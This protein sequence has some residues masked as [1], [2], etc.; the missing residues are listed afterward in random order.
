MRFDSS[1]KL[2]RA[3]VKSQDDFAATSMW[4]VKNGASKQVETVDGS[5]MFGNFDI[6]VKSTAKPGTELGFEFK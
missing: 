3:S 6:N 4:Q 1:D 2:N 5:S